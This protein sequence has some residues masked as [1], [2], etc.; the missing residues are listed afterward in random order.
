M[1]CYSGKASERKGM[2]PFREE[3]MINIVM[4]RNREEGVH[5]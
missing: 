4:D 3:R 5:K 2:R 1:I